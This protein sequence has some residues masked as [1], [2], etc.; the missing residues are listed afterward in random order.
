[1]K[2]RTLVVVN[3]KNSDRAVNKHIVYEKQ[4]EWER[5][6]V[7]EIANVLCLTCNQ[8]PTGSQFSILHEPN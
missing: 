1:M 4:N 2:W 8:K 7:N 6:I 5:K 3:I